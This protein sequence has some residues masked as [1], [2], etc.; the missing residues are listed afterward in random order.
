MKK[1]NSEK[2]TNENSA[3]RKGKSLGVPGGNCFQAV[4]FVS[5]EI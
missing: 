1:K 2:N 4:T 5:Y 3:C